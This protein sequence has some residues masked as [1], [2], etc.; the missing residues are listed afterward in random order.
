MKIKI[1][2]WMVFA[3][4]VLTILVAVVVYLINPELLKQ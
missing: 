3:L 4:I 1:K 2:L